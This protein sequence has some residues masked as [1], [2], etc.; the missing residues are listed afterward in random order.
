[1]AKRDPSEGALTPSLLRNLSDRQYE[2]RKLAALDIETRI[3]ELMDTAGE[4]RHDEIERIIN[5]LG[6]DYVRVCV[7]V[8]VCKSRREREK[9]RDK[10]KTRERERARE[11]E[12]V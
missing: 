5:V 12:S 4:G 2:K 9:T 7:R 11:R 3:K 10:R 6:R 1:M 8:C